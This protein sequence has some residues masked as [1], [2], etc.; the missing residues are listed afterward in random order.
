MMSTI[1]NLSICHLYHGFVLCCIRY[2][3]GMPLS[4]VMGSLMARFWSG[5]SSESCVAL[6]QVCLSHIHCRHI[7]YPFFYLIL[8]SDISLSNV[9][10]RCS[11]VFS[12]YWH[13]ALVLS[14]VSPHVSVISYLCPMFVNAIAPTSGLSPGPSS[15]WWSSS[16]APDLQHAAFAECRSHVFCVLSSSFFSMIYFNDTT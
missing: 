13:H 8:S 2:L 3:M 11:T 7:G 4:E 15:P 5:P 10:I 12:M 16:N 6:T 14:R 9:L 1:V